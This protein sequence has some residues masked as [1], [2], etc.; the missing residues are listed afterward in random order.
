M[1]GTFVVVDYDES[2]MFFVTNSKTYTTKEEL[3]V[4]TAVGSTVISRALSNYGM[5]G[6]V[7]GIEEESS[8]INVEWEGGQRTIINIGSVEFVSI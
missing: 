8:Y 5:L 3:F 7:V 1:N 2:Q 6:K 4:K